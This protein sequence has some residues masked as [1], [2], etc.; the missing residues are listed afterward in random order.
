VKQFPKND[1]TV[2]TLLI[3]L[4]ISCQTVHLGKCVYLFDF[5]RD[6]ALNRSGFKEKR[7][8]EASAKQ[9]VIEFL[10]LQKIQSV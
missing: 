8:E 9:K 2:K 6:K 5:A 1:Y 3:L 7:K 10:F 4:C